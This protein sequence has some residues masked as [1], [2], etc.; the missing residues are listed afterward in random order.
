MLNKDDPNMNGKN[1]DTELHSTM[2]SLRESTNGK[3]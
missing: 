3:K 1:R 2:K